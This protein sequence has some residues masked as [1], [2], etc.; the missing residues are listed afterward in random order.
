MEIENSFKSNFAKRNLAL[1]NDIDKV[2]EYMSKY[3]YYHNRNIIDIC[4]YKL[5]YLIDAI[6][7]SDNYYQDFKKRQLAE[8]IDN[9]LWKKE[10]HTDICI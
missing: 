6:I 7:T 10:S 5:K 3:T 2:I 9:E 8:Q 1:S 4:F